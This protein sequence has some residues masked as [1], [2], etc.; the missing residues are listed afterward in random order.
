MGYR[1][2]T[3]DPVVARPTST[4]ERPL[5]LAAG[6]SMGLH[7]HSFRV[8]VVRLGF[9]VRVFS[10]GLNGKMWSSPK[11]GVPLRKYTGY[12]LRRGIQGLSDE[13]DMS[14]FSVQGLGLT[15]RLMGLSSYL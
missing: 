14:E 4:G 1:Y 12:K 11:L 6:S 2:R 3:Y 7:P 10:L 5:P 8:R 13:G 9:T 15:G